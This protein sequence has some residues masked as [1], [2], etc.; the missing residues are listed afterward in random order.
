MEMSKTSYEDVRYSTRRE[1]DVWVVVDEER[2]DQIAARCSQA[3][4][5]EL[6]AALM[7]GDMTALANAS[8][9]TAQR[10]YSAIGGALLVVSQRFLI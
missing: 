8:A 7:N 6:I 9:E 4:E 1:G 5:A 2:D 3:A 10:S